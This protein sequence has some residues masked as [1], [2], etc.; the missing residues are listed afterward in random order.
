MY[1]SI[2]FCNMASIPHHIVIES[3]E[4]EGI[5]LISPAVNRSHGAQSLVQPDQPEYLQGEDWDLKSY[6]C[7]LK[8]DIWHLGNQTDQQV[9]MA[10]RFLHI[11]PTTEAA[12]P[13]TR[14]LQTWAAL[15][16]IRKHKGRFCPLL[17]LL[18]LL[19]STSAHR[20]TKCIQHLG[21]SKTQIQ[22]ECFL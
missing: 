12:C 4:L 13:R 8:K 18:S 10:S 11:K 1:Y 9:S 19:G 3:F 7:P 14:S 5:P 16:C 17:T 15:H 22:T 20:L 6:Q 2:W 21:L